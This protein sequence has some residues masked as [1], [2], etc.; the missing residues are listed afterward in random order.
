LASKCF[1]ANSKERMVILFYISVKVHSPIFWLVAL[2]FSFSTSLVWPKMLSTY[3]SPPERT[4]FPQFLWPMAGYCAMICKALKQ[5]NTIPSQV[6][7]LYKAPNLRQMVTEVIC[8]RTK[9]NGNEQLAGDHSTFHSLPH[10][11][12]VS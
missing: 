8:I 10:Q 2:L 3:P 7:S 1:Q 6:Y 5:I 12:L 4:H 11:D 9:C